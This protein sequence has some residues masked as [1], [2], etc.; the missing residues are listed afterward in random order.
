MKTKTAAAHLSACPDCR[1]F[2]ESLSPL[3]R[4]IRLRAARPVPDGLVELLTPGPGPPHSS[5]R[6]ITR[7][8]GVPSLSNWRSSARWACAVVPA[9]IAIPALALGAFAHVHII[10]THV[11]T[12]CTASLGLLHHMRRR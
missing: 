6:T 8:L 10:P 11:V 3:A 4:Q 2:L 12:P 9:G 5:T 1:A 7:Y